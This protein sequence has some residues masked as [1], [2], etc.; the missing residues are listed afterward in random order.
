MKLFISYSRD[1]KA[2]VYELWRNLRDELHLDVWIDQHV[3]PA[4]DWWATICKNIEDADVFIYVMTK[5]AVDSIYCTGELNYALALNKPILPLMLK[6]CDYPVALSKERVQYQVITDMSMDT[7]LLKI[8]I[9]L[10]EIQRQTYK[11]KDAPR[12]DVPTPQKDPEHI[13][14]TFVVAE[15]AAAEGNITLAEQLFSQ[16]IEADKDGLGVEARER[17]DEIMQDQERAVAYDNVKRLASNPITLKGAK[18]AWRAFKRAYGEF[19]PDNL[20]S[21]L[22]VKSSRQNTPN[23]KVETISVQK[24]SKS[25]ALMPAPFDWIEIPGGNGTMTTYGDEITL[26]IPKKTYAISKYPVTNA[27]FAKFKDAGGYNTERWWTDEGWQKRYEG[28][29][30]DGNDWNPS[31][32]RWT[33]PHFWNDSEMNSE[34]QPIVGVSWFEA[35]AFCLW[36]NEEMDEDEKKIMLPTEAQWQ[37]AAQGTDGRAYPWDDKWDKARCQ[38]NFDEQTVKTSPVTEYEGREKGSSPFGVEDMSGNVWEW[39]RTG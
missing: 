10:M 36:L 1:D 29:R 6:T 18:A 7:V 20:D 3:V 34:D 33:K 12:P 24:V 22:R 16:V 39:C 19:D 11:P 25:K 23:S 35:V 28:W 21:K 38:N 4:Q 27:Q 37:Y 26:A 31:K 5:K 13:F 14:E 30:Y 15:E 8:M 2:W 17:I 32:K 9:G